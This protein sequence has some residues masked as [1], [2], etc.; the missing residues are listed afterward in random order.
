ML[1]KTIG[2]LVDARNAVCQ[3]ATPAWP[4]LGDI[5]L[6]WLNNRLGVCTDDIRAWTAG[7]FVNRSIAE[8]IRRLVRVRNLIASNQILYVCH[9]APCNPGETA[10]G[11]DTWAFTCIDPTCVQTVPT[12]VRLC[13]NFWVAAANTDVALRNHAEFQAQT[14]IHEAS[15]L[16]H[17]T[18]DNVGSSI[19]VAECLAQFVAATNDSPMDPLFA[20]RC[21]RTTRCAVVA[22]AGAKRD[23]GS[24]A[25]L[26]I[27]RVSAV[28]SKRIVLATVFHPQNAIRLKGRPAVRRDRRPATLG[29]GGP[30]FGEPPPPIPGDVI[31]PPGNIDPGI[32]SSPGPTS[33][34]LAQYA[35]VRGAIV[36]QLNRNLRADDERRIL[37]R[38]QILRNLFRS[39][40]QSLKADLLGRL[41][42]MN[43]PLARR[44]HG[45]L[46]HATRKEMMDIL[47]SGNVV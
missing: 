13:R 44:F 23:A 21:A 36:A 34:E 19:G 18:S 41:L 2:E 40:P 20:D 26:G 16:F 4:L 38:R 12:V 27:A 3:G 30:R 31:P 43:D 37:E 17:C 25:Q 6:D 45:R 1:D 11:P 14:I 47:S 33:A 46:H 9:P 32:V 8:V 5:T 29:Y 22:A 10:C 35:A 15:H 28:G 7:T 24:G 39:V 42:N